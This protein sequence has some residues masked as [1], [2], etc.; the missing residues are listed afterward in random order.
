V[1]RWRLVRGYG[2]KSQVRWNFASGL[3]ANLRLGYRQRSG[4]PAGE[5]FAGCQLELAK[6]DGAAE[7]KPDTRVA[8]SAQR[9][10]A[11][12]VARIARFGF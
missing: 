1:E 3:E 8:V 11:N 9:D 7:P 6:G 4:G 5:W 10:P 2:S 12:P